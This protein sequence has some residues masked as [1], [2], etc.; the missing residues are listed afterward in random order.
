MNSLTIENTL[1]T[2]NSAVSSSLQKLSSGLRINT[3]ADDP[4]GF[5]IANAFKASIASMQVASQNASQ[6]QSMLQTADGA[7]SQ[8][9]NILVQMKSIATEA[10]SGQESTT[11][12]NSLQNEF[13]DLQ[14]EIDQISKSTVYGGTTLIAGSGK[15]TAGTVVVTFQIG[16]TNDKN[17]YDQ[18]AVSLVS[19]TTEG[20]GIDFSH[21]SIGTQASAQ[22]AMNALDKALTS[23]NAYMGTVGGFQNQLQYAMSN[24]TRTTLPRRQR[25]KTWTWLRK[26]AT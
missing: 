23:I 25:S 7:Y 5:A 8:I 10:S 18:F 12:L 14:S 6:A 17:H 24:L 21:A 22:N 1:T 3:A 26:S 13:T 9:N 20:L 4:A 11:N 16:A 2:T 15:G 19:A